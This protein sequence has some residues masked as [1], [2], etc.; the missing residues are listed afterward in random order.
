MGSR[1]ETREAIIEAG[2][3]CVAKIG[4]TRMSVE[5]V[6]TAAGVSRATMYRYFPGG[7]GE[8]IDAVVTWEYQRFF[9]RLYEAVADAA[10]LEEIMERGIL[11]AHRSIKEHEVLQMV[12]R[13]EP[14]MLEPALRAQSAPSRTL[15]ATF[16]TPYLEAHELDAGVDVAQA[17]DFLARMFLSYIGS[18][19][20]WDLADEAEVARLVR[21]ELLAGIVP[22]VA[23]IR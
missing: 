16:L 21:A 6:A 4:P 22:P 5:D 8:V 10:T 13:T 2:Y 15:V 23:P 9:L 17:A 14:E 11:V 20:R 12:L 1:P 3:A 18:P 19:G 7:R